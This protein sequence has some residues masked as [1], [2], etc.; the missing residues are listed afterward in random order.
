MLNGKTKIFVIDDHPLVREWLTTLIHQQADLEVCGAADNAPEALRRMAAVKPDLTIVDLSLPGSSGVELI[1]TI[2]NLFPDVLLIVLSMHDEKLYAERAIR[3]GARGYVMK[4]ETAERIIGAIYEV[5]QNKISVS[6][7]M[8][9]VFTS[10]FMKDGISTDLSPVENLSDRELEI[11][12]QLGQGL[13][14]RNIAN[15][16]HLSIKTVQTYCTRIKE[17][18]SLANATEL[19]REAIRWNESAPY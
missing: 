9:G 6:D 14:T 5:L 10:K 4:R 18:L 3:A 2:K 13:D 15:N 11:F 19:L 17:K 7:E 1:K 12:R 16:L 8:M